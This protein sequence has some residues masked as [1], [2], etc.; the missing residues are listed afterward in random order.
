MPGTQCMR[1]TGP[2]HLPTVKGRVGR[3]ACVGVWQ[4]AAH[5]GS[6]PEVDPWTGR[7][8]GPVSATEAGPSTTAASPPRGRTPAGRAGGIRSSDYPDR[9]PVAAA[10]GRG[11]GRPEPGLSGG[12]S[13]GYWP[14]PTQTGPRLM[15]A[16]V[17]TW[18]SEVTREPL[19][20]VI[21]GPAQASLRRVFGCRECTHRR[22]HHRLDSAR[23][24]RTVS[25]TDGRCRSADY[26]AQVTG[27][28]GTMRSIVTST[29]SSA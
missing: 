15:S 2:P 23:Q 10:P 12:L 25:D 7:G 16:L 1:S 13:P 26:A 19:R 5:L 27:P 20:R 14:P 9:A 29:L 17:I 21:R 8:L 4:D 22:T 24:C 3:F 11:P 18:Q 28:I 6:P